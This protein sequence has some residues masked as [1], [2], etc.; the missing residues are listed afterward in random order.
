MTFDGWETLLTGDAMAL[1]TGQ[2][3]DNT[4]MHFR[5]K[6]SKNGVR[7]YQTESGEWTPLG[8]KER[9]IREG[10]GEKRAARKMAKSVAK[11]ERKV[12]RLSRKSARSEARADAA[13]KRRKSNVKTMTDEELQKRIQRLKLEK[14]YRELNKN[15]L[16]EVGQNIVKSYLDNKNAKAKREMDLAN[17]QIRD[18]EARAKLASA[19]AANTSAKNDL[20]DNLLR[21]K[22]HMKARSE[23]LKT[24]ADTTVTGAIRKGIAK[25]V[26]K[27]T[28]GIVKDMPDHSVIVSGAKKVAK[29]GRKAGEAT[30]EFAKAGWDAAGDAYGKLLNEVYVNAKNKR[31][32]KA[33]KVINNLKG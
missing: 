16:V 9:K 30:K 11:A 28:S 10:W 19:K 22:G 7:R 33:R 25:I 2:L 23:L 32:K 3:S 1:P 4:L 12:A 20:L 5:T 15:P 24:K 6:G 29:G 17:L 13:E 27:E 18:I 14:E 31:S 26:S 21:G 8:L